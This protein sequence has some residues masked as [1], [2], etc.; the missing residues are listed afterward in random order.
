[1]KITLDAVF[2]AEI[3][4]RLGQEKGLELISRLQQLEDQLCR[5]MI[6]PFIKGDLVPERVPD[7]LAGIKT[8]KKL[9]SLNLLSAAKIKG[10]RVHTIISVA[11]SSNEL[12]NKVIDF[13]NLMGL[14]QVLVRNPTRLQKVKKRI[15]TDKERVT[16]EETI[17]ELLDEKPT[18]R[19]QSWFDFDYVFRSDATF[20]KVMQKRVFAGVVEV[21]PTKTPTVSDEIELA[22]LPIVAKGVASQIVSKLRE[23]REWHTQKTGRNLPMTSILKDAIIQSATRLKGIKSDASQILGNAMHRI[24]EELGDKGLH[25]SFKRYLKRKI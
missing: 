7:V 5:S 1:M 19:K 11:D 2:A 21:G 13:W 4:V 25:V 10:A 9:A 15:K 20:E 18:L 24:D 23:F 8:L 3:L 12:A 14:P 16:F 17:R 6:N 22:L